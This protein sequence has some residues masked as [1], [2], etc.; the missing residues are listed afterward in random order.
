MKRPVKSIKRA[1]KRPT[2]KLPTLAAFKELPLI[3]RT[4]LFAR[5]CRTQRGDYAYMDT[6]D[7]ALARFGKAMS[8]ARVEASGTCFYVGEDRLEIS[9]GMATAIAENP[10]TFHAL[11]KRLNA[12]IAQQ[13]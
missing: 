1:A 5:F 7:C 9:D 10:S 13:A 12:H 6:Y 4:K 11:T 3:E 8:T 2:V